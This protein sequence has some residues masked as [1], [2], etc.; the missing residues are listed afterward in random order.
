MLEATSS[1]SHAFA[2]AFEY[3]AEAITKTVVFPVLFFARLNEK[4]DPPS[5]T[6]DEVFKHAHEAISQ[7]DAEVWKSSLIL[8]PAQVERRWILFAVC[9]ANEARSSQRVLPARQTIEPGEVKPDGARFCVLSLDPEGRSQSK[10]R[11]LIM[12]YLKYDYL[13]KTGEALEYFESW[14]CKAV[15]HSHLNSFN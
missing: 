4:K 15:G 2:Q 12:D 10:S 13:Q 3:E 5:G 1:L 7:Y 8:I 11:R 6:R 9:N 14:E